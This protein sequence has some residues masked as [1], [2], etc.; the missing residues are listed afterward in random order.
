MSQLKKIHREVEE[1][2]E[3]EAKFREEAFEPTLADCEQYLAFSLRID[4][5]KSDH[6]PL[7]QKRLDAVDPV[8]KKPRYGPGTSEKVRFMIEQVFELQARMSGEREVVEN[9]QQALVREMEEQ[10]REEQRKSQGEGGSRGGVLMG[11]TAV[12]REESV[13]S[14]FR[15]FSPSDSEQLHE[16]AERERNKRRKEREDAMRSKMTSSLRLSIGTMKG[17]SG[18]REY[19]RVLLQKHRAERETGMEAERR[20]KEAMREKREENEDINK[21][22]ISMD[23]IEETDIL[24]TPLLHKTEYW[25]VLEAIHS[26]LQR[27]VARPEEEAFRKLNTNNTHFKVFMFL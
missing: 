8:T 20:A 13:Q 26:L 7:F 21:S 11:Q 4:A 5:I 15:V 19:T 9:L 3:F 22:R 10:R 24:F 1:I 2:A 12:S 23:E 6:L 18:V 17:E 16:Q 25:K 27:I 14:R